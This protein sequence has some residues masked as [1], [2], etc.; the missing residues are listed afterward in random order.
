MIA[1][2]SLRGLGSGSL[3]ASLEDSCEEFDAKAWA[4]EFECDYGLV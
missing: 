1:I 3:L 4:E 2:R